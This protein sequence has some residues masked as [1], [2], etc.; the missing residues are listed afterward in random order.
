MCDAYTE[1]T[2]NTNVLQIFCWL[3][4]IFHSITAT[5]RRTR[6]AHTHTASVW[7][8]FI[9]VYINSSEWIP[10][11]S[12]FVSF[13]FLV[14]HFLVKCSRTLYKS[15]CSFR[16]SNDALTAFRRR[17]WK[18]V[19]RRRRF[20]FKSDAKEMK[21]VARRWN[22]FAHLHIT[23][24]TQC[25]NITDDWRHRPKTKSSSFHFFVPPF[26]RRVRVEQAMLSTLF[27]DPSNH[28]LES[29]LRQRS[30][31]R[32]GINCCNTIRNE[33]MNTGT[34]IH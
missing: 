18:W 12:C 22:S 11:F 19:Q 33:H 8:F 31:R 21:R 27:E 6:I 29:C 26:P 5:D 10:F 32:H 7:I 23:H 1:L 2:N 15:K 28:T 13:P 20:V 14:R 9:F 4:F 24:I 34:E 30:T 3:L 25:K 16:A 17:R